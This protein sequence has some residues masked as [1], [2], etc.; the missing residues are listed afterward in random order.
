MSWVDLAVACT[1]VIAVVVVPGLVLGTLLGLRGLSAWAAAAPFGVTVV[2]TAAVAAPL[3]GLSWSVLP[4]AIVTVIFAAVIVAVRSLTP[5]GWTRPGEVSAQG[6][7]WWIVGILAAAGVII[8][9]QIVWVIGEPD[10]ISQTFDNIFHLNAIRYA[11]DNSNAS[12]LFVGTLTSVSGGQ[13]FYPTAWHAV[14]ALAV[15][16]TGVS[17]PVAA[18]AMALAFSIVVW[19]AGALWLATTL[20]GR[21]PGVLVGAGLAIVGSSAFPLLMIDYGVL[22]PMHMGFA[23]LPAS[24]ALLVRAFGIVRLPGVPLPLTIVAVLGVVPGLAITHPGALA[25]WLVL[26]TVAVIFFIA[27]AVRGASTTRSV[28]IGIGV[29][30]YL[31]AASAIWWVLRPPVDARTWGPEMTAAQALGEVI[32]VSPYRAPLALFLALLTATGVVSAVRRRSAPAMFAFATFAVLGALYVV[33]AS[34]PYP[35]VRDFLTGSWYNNLPR[36]AAL[37][38]MAVV[39]LAG[40]GLQALVLLATR[41]VTR[42]EPAIRV[43]STALFIVAAVLV[44]L[45][46]MRAPLNGAST[47]YALDA[48]S[49]LVSADEMTLMKR[50][51][52][53]VEPDAVIA[54]SP[55]TGAGLAYAIS[56]RRVLQPHTL[57]EITD[58][59]VEINDDLNTARPGTPVC[60][61]VADT[62]VRYVLDFGTREV[63]GGMHPYPGFRGLVAS[64]AAELVD[65][66]GE[67]KLYR[68]IGCGL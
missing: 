52:A 56:G 60:A 34:L 33:V 48:N 50:L 14:A 38:P 36:L 18:N 16:I 35:E 46:P 26:T 45:L 8:A 19:P 29:L 39:P 55:W 49:P 1:T 41:R 10:N 3:V 59:I 15:D 31:A 62:G 40:A 61:A 47:T 13:W 23:L 22:Y 66:E 9:A 20:F 17:I 2:S 42:V 58:D 21:R 7:R 43:T 32:F 6:G 30:V 28:M 37:L 24:V 12:P 4:V 27:R 67:A 65:R 57:M 54:G 5:R 64:G 53:D 68:V 25:A 44:T 63:H 51:D 11:V